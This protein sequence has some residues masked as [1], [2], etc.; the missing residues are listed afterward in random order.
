MMTSTPAREERRDART[1]LPTRGPRLPGRSLAVIGRR[2][3]VG[4]SR[5]RVASPAQPDLEH[6]K[7][8]FGEF[9]PFRVVYVLREDLHDVAKAVPFGRVDGLDA[10]IDRIVDR[11]QHDLSAH[12]PHPIRSAQHALLVAIHSNVVARVRA[13]DVVLS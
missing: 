9:T 2:G 5:R 10:T 8:A 1:S 13:G 7:F 3:T 11:M 12:V 4:P 6:I